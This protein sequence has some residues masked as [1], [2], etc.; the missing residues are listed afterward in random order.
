MLKKVFH[1]FM[2]G[3]F[4][5]SIVGRKSKPLARVLVT[6]REDSSASPVIEMPSACLHEATR[7]P[8]SWYHVEDSVLASAVGSL[9]SRRWP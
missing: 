5:K 7:L 6:Q 4:G 1:N 8:G 3:D 2:D 9:G